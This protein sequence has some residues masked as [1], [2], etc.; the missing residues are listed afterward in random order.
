MSVPFSDLRSYIRSALLDDD[1]VFN[2]Y[3]DSTINSQLRFSNL[4][5]GFTIQEISGDF[6]FIEDLTSIQ[7]I[8]MTIAIALR[9]IAGRPSEF[10]Y[11]SPI[12]SVVRK[13]QKSDLI[14]FLQDMLD[15]ASSGGGGRFSMSRYTSID[16]MSQEIQLFFNEFSDSFAS[17]NGRS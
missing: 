1:T 4:R 2:L 17:Y 12:L 9:M 11:K 10:S 5:Y 3:S 16:S 6:E 14:I 15:E 7:I 8:K 13:F